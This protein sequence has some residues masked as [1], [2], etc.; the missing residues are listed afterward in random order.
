MTRR[1][2]ESD[3]D[4]ERRRR[5]HR[6]YKL[7]I[8][9]VLMVLSC[10]VFLAGLRFSGVELQNLVWTSEVFDPEKNICLRTAWLNTT[11]GRADR[12][13][14]C[15]EWI[16][17]SDMSG[18]THTLPVKEVD[19]IRGGDGRIRTQF[20]RGINYRLVAVMSYLLVIIIGALFLQRSLIRRDQKQ[21]G[22]TP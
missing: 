10:L 20:K 21:M 17:H 5:K 4:L 3:E 19:I 8:T 18:E 22:L 12:V 11:Q 14:L 6:V 1:D 7:R 16:D 13:Q 2:A 15:T 9:A